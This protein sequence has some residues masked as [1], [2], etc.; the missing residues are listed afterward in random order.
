MLKS[1]KTNKI[2]KFCQDFENIFNSVD[3]IVLLLDFQGRILFLNKYS[4]DLLGYKE[5]ELLGK[6]FFDKCLEKN[7][8]RRL[9][10]V[11][12]SLI[13]KKKEFSNYENNVLKKDGSSL[14]ITWRNS[15]IEI[16]DNKEYILSIGMD[17]TE[18][19]NEK[20][21]IKVEER[22]LKAIL[23]S[24]QTGIMIIDAKSHEIVD[25]NPRAASMVGLSKDKILGQVCH[26]FVC[27]AEKGKCPITDLGLAVD[28]SEKALLNKNSEKV[29]IIKTVIPIISNGRKCLLE[30]FVDIT[31]QKEI[32]KDI[33]EVT[34]EWSLTFDSIN[35]LVIILD[36]DLNV[37]RANKRAKELAGNNIN[38]SKLQQCFSF[39]QGK[40]TMCEGCTIKRT[41]ATK[42]PSDIIIKNIFGDRVYHL[43]FY[44]VLNEDGG[45]QR[46]IEYGKDVTEDEKTKTTLEQQKI[47]NEK[48][49]KEWELIFDSI[50]DYIILLDKDFHIINAN[51]KAR[52]DLKI[53]NF[54]SIKT[55]K[56]FEITQKLTDRCPGCQVKELIKTKKPINFS[57]KYGAR[58]FDVWQYPVLDNAGNIDNI[59]EYSRDVTE[60]QL[61]K[62]KNLFLANIIR[63]SLETIIVIDFN[64]KI[65]EW[66]HGAEE[67]LGYKREEMIGKSVF[68][69]IP[70]SRVEETK[71]C[72]NQI[73]A[74]EF[75]VFESERI[76][77]NKKRIP[78]SVFAYLI[79]DSSDKPIAVSTFVRDIS[80]IKKQE[81]SLNEHLEILEQKN[82]ELNTLEKIVVSREL[83]MIELKKEINKF[84]Q[85]K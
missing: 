10:I 62:E 43:W 25:I 58:I 11:F 42:Q 78:V 31:K 71:S 60:E 7:I 85:G 8:K 70:Q 30:S 59:I 73:M 46:L 66:N 52:E 40:K 51:K 79:E 82:K 39:F 67:L 17:V 2:F 12:N 68:T 81:H 80:D 19:E 56:C 28:N 84:K 20:E 9:K 61:F 13:A 34:K 21:D 83:K 50:A 23:N 54:N 32:E 44:P 1:Y 3:S 77:K 26:K 14:Y 24:I 22:R 33:E 18:K 63:D 41:V 64:M 36:K 65:L 4:L 57:M 72:F 38:N 48:A 27:P 75:H 53:K 6:N 49:K 29:P 74:N 35:D 76:T 37:L 45:V 5:N 69:I 16:G 55:Q 47:S 15:Y